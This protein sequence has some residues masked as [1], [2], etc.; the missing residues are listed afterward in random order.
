MNNSYN[1][2]LFSNNNSCFNVTTLNNITNY[3]AASDE[4]SRILSWISPLESLERHR[5]VARVRAEGVGEWVLRSREFQA[6]RGNDRSVGR[7][8]ACHGAP[9]AGKTFIW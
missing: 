2:T 3:A 4:G 1:R 6:W 9:G 7:I 5:D 8:L